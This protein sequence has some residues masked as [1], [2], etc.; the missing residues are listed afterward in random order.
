MYYIFLSYLASGDELHSISL[1]YRIGRSTTS[2]IIR[3]TCEAI[4]NNLYKEVLFTPTQNGWQEIA[5]EFKETWN[6]PNCIGALDGK[7]VAIIV[8]F[9]K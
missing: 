5:Q 3:E 6:F 7:H 8:S 2:R 9:L 1:S 4:W